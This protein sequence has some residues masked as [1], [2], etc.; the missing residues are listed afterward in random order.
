MR[1]N[2]LC[3]SV[4]INR[5]GWQPILRQIFA[6]SLANH[7][8][9]RRI[10][11]DVQATGWIAY[12]HNYSWRLWIQISHGFLIQTGQCRYIDVF[13]TVRTPQ[14]EWAIVISHRGRNSTQKQSE[15]YEFRHDEQSNAYDCKSRHNT[16]PQQFVLI[17]QI[18]RKDLRRMRRKWLTGN[19]WCTHGAVG[20]VSFW[21][22]YVFITK[23]H[24]S[25]WFVCV[26]ACA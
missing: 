2:Y 16:F 9:E 5:I 14:Q 25:M 4:I 21:R 26:C 22:V 11:V 17:W 13:Q 23:G 19:V 1:D 8:G 24:G 3:I 18:D 7:T 15:N 10:I 20:S 12:K 6:G